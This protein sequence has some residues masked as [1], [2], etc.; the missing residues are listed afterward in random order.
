ME[1]AFD[2]YANFVLGQ[3]IGIRK[4]DWGACL[5]KLGAR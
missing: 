4:A 3:E 1:A 5:S 2:M